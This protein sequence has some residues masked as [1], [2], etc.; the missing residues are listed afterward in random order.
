M[1]EIYSLAALMRR[2]FYVKRVGG[3]GQDFGN[4]WGK[5]GLG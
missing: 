4:G 5:P 3:V 1:I 2:G